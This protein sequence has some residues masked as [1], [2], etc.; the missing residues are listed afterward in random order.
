MVT[1]DAYAAGI[2]RSLET[3]SK[4]QYWIVEKNIA[5]HIYKNVLLINN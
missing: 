2:Q 4:L 5:M 1:A 3:T